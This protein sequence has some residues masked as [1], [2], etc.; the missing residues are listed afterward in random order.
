MLSVVKGLTFPPSRL[1]P[2][3]TLESNIRH[4]IPQTGQVFLI[5]DNPA[6]SAQFLIQALLQSQLKREGEAS[7]SGRACVIVSVDHD[8][9]HISAIAARSNL[10]L[11]QCIRERTLV[12]VDALSQA[13]QP[14]GNLGDGEGAPDGPPGI[15]ICPPLAT[16]LRPLYDVIQRAFEQLS[17]STFGK[18]LI[19]GDVSTLE[20]IGIPATEVSRF[21]RAVR[22]LAVKNECGVVVLYHSPMRDLPIESGVLKDLVTSCDVHAEVRELSSG[23]SSAVSGEVA[24]HHGFTAP[25]PHFVAIPRERALQYRLTDAGVIWFDRGTSAGVL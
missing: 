16:S 13:S 21:V 5:T 25:D 6:S 7:G 23:L 9:A 19:L 14:P 17:P 18:L 15:V 22:A 24:L 12:Y 20:W 1:N 2:T 8:F 11:A 3:P 10:N 4:F